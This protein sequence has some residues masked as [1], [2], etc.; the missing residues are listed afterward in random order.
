VKCNYK[1]VA[2][3]LFISFCCNYQEGGGVFSQQKSIDYTKEVHPV[4]SG[5]IPL[6]EITTVSLSLVLIHILL[7]PLGTS[8]EQKVETLL[9]LITFSV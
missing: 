7:C 9:E 1:K 6:P 2:D 8:V 3:V 4:N 5:Y